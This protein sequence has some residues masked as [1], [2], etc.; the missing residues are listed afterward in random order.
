VPTLLRNVDIP[1]PCLKSGDPALGISPEEYHDALTCA[2]TSPL[3]VN[4]SDKIHHPII[5]ILFEGNMDCRRF[6]GE[7]LPQGYEVVVRRGVC[8]PLTSLFDVLTMLVEDAI[9]DILGKPP[10]SVE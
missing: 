10:L 8:R 2:A 5:E 6:I 1:I 9:G 7:R 3:P 4:P